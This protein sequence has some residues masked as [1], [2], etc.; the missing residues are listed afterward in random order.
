MQGFA[1]SQADS[2]VTS[3]GSLDLLVRPRARFD[4]V[5]LT[6]HVDRRVRAHE[7]EEGACVVFARHT[8]CALIINE[9]ERG[10][11]VDFRRRLEDLFPPDDY[12]EHDDLSRRTQNLVAGERRNGHAHVAQ[13]L[14]GGSS[15]SVPVRDGCLLLGRWQRII[16]VE[17][18]GPKER[19][20]AVELLGRSAAQAPEKR[21]AEVPIVPRLIA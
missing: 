4:F 10:A 8:T 13:M 19:L 14:I 7:L 18:D 16:F 3:Q 20:I 17:L 9:W 15:L 11:L 2:R 1:A 21:S 12:Y 5:D 6:Y